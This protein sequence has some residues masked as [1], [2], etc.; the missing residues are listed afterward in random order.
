[1]TFVY[2]C[3]HLSLPR[4]DPRTYFPLYLPLIILSPSFDSLDTEHIEKQLAIVYD[5][6][7]RRLSGETHEGEST[8]EDKKAKIG[9]RFSN[10]FA[11]MTGRGTPATPVI[12]TGGGSGADDKAVSDAL[13]P[14]VNELNR[15]DNSVEAMRGNSTKSNDSNNT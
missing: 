15:S 13:A 2:F 3:I 9:E 10:I 1:M 8:W 6:I 11:R 7:K 5:R 12:A 4:P 14:L